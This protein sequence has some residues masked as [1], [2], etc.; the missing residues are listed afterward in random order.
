[1]EDNKKILNVPTLRFPEFN[2]SWKTA[3]LTTEATFLKGTILSKND[4][5]E[6]GRPCIL[7]GQL[8]TTYKKET[9]K[10]VFSKTSNLMDNLFVGKTNDVIIPASGETPEDISTACCVLPDGI[11]FGGD[12]NVIRTNHNGSFLSYQLNGK[13]KYDIAKLAVGKSIVHLHNDQ[14]KK[15][16]CSFPPN[17]E[18]ENKIVALLNNIDN[19]I[20]T[21]NKII[22]HYESL[23]KGIRHKLVYNLKRYIYLND[24]C[25][26]TTGKLDANNN[27]KNGRYPFFTCGREPL[28]I[29]DYA[30][31]CEA[32]LISGNGDIGHTK[33]Y[34]GKFNAYQ[35]TYV[36][37]DFKLD[38]NYVKIA[39]DEKLPKKI[40]DETQNGAMPFIRIN[41]LATLEIPYQD[42]ITNTQISNI[43][44]T[45]DE[46]LKKEKDILTLYTRQ[47]AYLLSNLFI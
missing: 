19:L 41:T 25:K 10:E 14:L 26:I 17:I 47:K 35:R 32:L 31:D 37:Y 30:F 13:R 40:K 27:V 2:K 9:I 24:I 8:Y 42:E 22:E 23:I 12:L 7:Y 16:L 18:E 39:I 43:I 15:L 34:K 28:K 4:L 44:K 11:L 1:M 45:L 5:A 29:N 38:P 3:K 46:F 20:E 36:L 33:Y 6:F 21:Q